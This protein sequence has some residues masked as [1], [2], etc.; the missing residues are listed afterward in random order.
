MNLILDL[1]TYFGKFP[2]KDGVLK[3]FNRGEEAME[4]YNDLKQLITDMDPHSLLPEIKD[5][6][7]GV[8]EM[9]LTKQIN[10]FSDIYLFVDYGAISIERDEIHRENG[11]LNIGVTVA[12][13]FNH[14]D[15]DAIESMLLAQKTLDL[16][17][18]IRTEMLDD[19]QCNIPWLKDLT[20]PHE[21]T[22]WENRELN[23]STGWSMIFQ[24]RGIGLI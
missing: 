9:V 4:G 6:A 12:T 3:C 10:Q 2:L 7:V 16:L 19:Q 23:N 21:I 8:N 22:P 20:F 11:S 13:P 5:F 14:N 1:I 18:A 24:K 15:R 17:K